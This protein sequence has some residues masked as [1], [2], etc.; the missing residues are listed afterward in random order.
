MMKTYKAVQIDNA[1]LS[2]IKNHVKP[3]RKNGTFEVTAESFAGV[4]AS[5]RLNDYMKELERF[6]KANKCEVETVKAVYG[7]FDKTYIVK[8]HDVLVIDVINEVIERFGSK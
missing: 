3:T 7:D 1:I 8:F 6:G 5:E 4:K 2:T